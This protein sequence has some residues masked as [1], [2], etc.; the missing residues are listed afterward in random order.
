MHGLERRAAMALV[1]FAL[2]YAV[3]IAPWPGLGRAW[4]GAIGAIATSI[5]DPFFAST[6]VTFSLRA[7]GPGDPTSEWTGIIELRQDLP[8]TS[9]HN[10]GA[11]DLRRCGYVQFVTFAALAIARPPRTRRRAWIALGA[12]VVVVAGS[13]GMPI[14][15]FIAPLGAV[16]PGA[17]FGA[18][19]ALAS[20]ALVA[21]PGMSYAVPGVV[22]VL[23]AFGL[24]PLARVARFD[25]SVQ[26]GSTAEDGDGSRARRSFALDRS[27]RRPML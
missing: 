23:T 11:I 22:W 24:E 3:A 17:F 13:V 9:S 27:P 20:R 1:R 19:I 14:L 26:G 2:V 6:N 12:S 18:A 16:H 15:A 25:R 4:G 10:A 5:A 7:S 21:A 8:D